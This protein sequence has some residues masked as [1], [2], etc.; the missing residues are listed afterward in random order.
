MSLADQKAHLSPVWARYNDIIVDRG[1]GV[2]LYGDDG[3]AFFLGTECP[4]A[5]S[6]S[7]VEHAGAVEIKRRHSLL[8]KFPDFAK[9]LDRLR[10]DSGAYFDFVIPLE[11]GDFGE[12]DER[13]FGAELVGAA[14]DGGHDLPVEGERQAVGRHAPGRVPWLQT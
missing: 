7:Y 14:A 1:E 5:V 11:L 12:D 2:M 13:V 8:D 9:P 6:R 10:H 3:R 4:L